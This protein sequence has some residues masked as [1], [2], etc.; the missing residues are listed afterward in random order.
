MDHADGIGGGVVGAEGIRADELGETVRLVGVG[1][2]HAA[3]FVEDYGYAG[4]GDL[5]GGFRAGQPA[6]DDVDGGE[7]FVSHA[8]LIS[9]LPPDRNQK[10]TRWVPLI[11]RLACKFC[12]AWSRLVPRHPTISGTSGLRRDGCRSGSGRCRSGPGWT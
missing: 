4:L 7:G 1:A 12:D 10:G 5:P 6:A 2:A 8:A 11:S 3:H 9:R